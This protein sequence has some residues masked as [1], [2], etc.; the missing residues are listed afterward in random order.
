MPIIP[1]FVRGTLMAADPTEHQDAVISRCVPQPLAIF[2][3]PV[4]TAAFK[5]LEIP[6]SVLFCKDDTSLPP[7][8]YLGMAQAELGEFD[9]AEIDGGHETVFINPSGF[10]EGLLKVI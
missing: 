8:A 5:A 2:S 7:G 6:K 10:V 1:D 3:T 9:L 4:S